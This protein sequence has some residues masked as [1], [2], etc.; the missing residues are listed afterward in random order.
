MWAVTLPQ[1]YHAT[2]SSP[3]STVV[4][5]GPFFV[6]GEGQVLTL[7]P[8]VGSQN[9]ETWVLPTASPLGEQS[10]PKP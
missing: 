3:F 10:T 1:D 4:F 5:G 6:M 2:I 8:T 7:G 9:F